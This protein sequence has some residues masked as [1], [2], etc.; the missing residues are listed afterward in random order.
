[1]CNDERGGQEVVGTEPLPTTDTVPPP[2]PMRP[3]VRPA[4]TPDC[5]TDTAAGANPDAKEGGP[6]AAQRWSRVLP[7]DFDAP[8]PQQPLLSYAIP[9]LRAPGAD[10]PDLADLGVRPVLGRLA[11]KAALRKYMGLK[12]GT[13]EVLIGR[14]RERLGHVDLNKLAERI[15]AG[16]RVAT[17]VVDLITA[18]QQL[19]STAR[20][21]ASDKKSAKG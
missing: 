21:T 19:R 14:L 8:R 7:D 20:G 6:S 18:V 2:P 11:V 9:R 1:M 3:A 15:E 10:V 17:A 4:C 5:H 13:G 16:T 12:P